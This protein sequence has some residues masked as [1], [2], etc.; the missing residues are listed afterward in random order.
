M[1]RTFVKVWAVF[2][3]TLLLAVMARAGESGNPAM[4]DPASFGK[5]EEKAFADDQNL[6]ELREHATPGPMNFITLPLLNFYRVYISPA[7]GFHCPMYPS[8]SSY[9]KEAFS[10]FNPLK[11]FWMTS[12]RLTRC[13]HDLRH[14]PVVFQDG[15]AKFYDPISV[16]P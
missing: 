9:G 16:S 15:V 5:S 13:G 14:Y 8:C 3:F 1:P 6:G 12:D 4:K 2:G 10:R 11:A 7:K